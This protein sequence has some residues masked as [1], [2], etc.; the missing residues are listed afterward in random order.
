MKEDLGFFVD[1]PQ[2]GLTEEAEEVDGGLDVQLPDHCLEF[3]KQRTV[4]GDLESG[5]RKGFQKSGKCVEGSSQAF[6]WDEA[7]GLHNCPGAIFGERSVNIGKTVERNTGP[8][9]PD[10][11]GIAI[12]LDKE[13]GDRAAPNENER[14]DAKKLA[15]IGFVATLGFAALNVHSVKG[16]DAGTVPALDQRKQM[17]T[18]I[19][20]IDVHEVGI[21][22]DQDPADQIEFATVNE[23]RCAREV[24]QTAPF[25]RADTRL[26]E[27][28]DIGERIPAGVFAESGDNEG[29]NTLKRGD[30]AVN[31]EHLRFEKISAKT[32]NES[33]AI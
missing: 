2:F 9:E 32:G 22:P 7:A 5:V 25:Q 19:P 3:G 17:D 31:V 16:D 14:C 33:A 24:F 13:T 8:V 11:C 10:F 6:L 15:K 27:K 29:V 26:I 20:E 12:K 21:A 1:I 30:L 23:R 4:P 28:L 18:G